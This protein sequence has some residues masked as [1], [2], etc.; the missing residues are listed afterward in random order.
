MKIPTR[1]GDRNYLGA[2]VKELVTVPGIEQVSMNPDTAGILIIHKLEMG[3]IIKNLT[4]SNH[5]RLAP[6]S[7]SQAEKTGPGSLHGLLL[8]LGGYRDHPLKEPPALPVVP[9]EQ[10][11]NAGEVIKASGVAC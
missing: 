2:V 9:V 1:K 8:F 4:V 6:L 7:E 3:K 5:F 10:S 11:L